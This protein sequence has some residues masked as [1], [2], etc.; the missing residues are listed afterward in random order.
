MARLVLVPADDSERASPESGLAC[1]DGID[2]DGD[3]FADFPDD[4]GCPFSWATPE[5]PQ[6]DDGADNDQNGLT[7]FADPKCQAN[8]PYWEKPVCG[9]GAELALLLPLLAAWRRHRAGSGH[10]HGGGASKVTIDLN[11]S[12]RFPS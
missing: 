6:C 10:S 3:Q 5:D 11:V 12:K 2:N 4:P 8:W 9:L 7:D 1:D